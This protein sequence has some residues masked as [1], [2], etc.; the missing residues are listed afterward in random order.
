MNVKFH[1]AM[2]TATRIVAQIQFTVNE[3]RQQRLRVAQI[4]F[5]VNESCQPRQHVDSWP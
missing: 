2:Q 1:L 4:Q 5:S 3:S